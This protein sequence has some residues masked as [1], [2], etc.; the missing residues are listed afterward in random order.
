MWDTI[1]KPPQYANS[2]IH[3]FFEVK[4]TAL[5]HYEDKYEDFIA[6]TV[7]LRRRFTQEGDGSLLRAGDDKL[8]ADSLV[9]ST[10]QIWDVIKSQKDLNLPAHKVMVAN[11]RCN[12]IKLDQLRNLTSDQAWQSMAQDSSSRLIRDFGRHSAALVDSCMKGYEVEAMYFD[13]NVRT[14]HQADLQAKLTATVSGPFK[15]QLN[16]LVAELMV[17]FD[18][19]FR[20]AILDNLLGAFAATAEKMSRDTL[21]AFDERVQEFLVTGTDL[22]AD[23]ARD[24]LAVELH[25]HIER[26][27]H[28]ATK[29]ALHAIEGE[30]TK[31]I[32][33]PAVE[34][35]QTFPQ[36]LWSKLDSVRK[37]A[38]ASSSRDLQQRLSGYALTA[39]EQKS[40]VSKLAAAADKKL[41]DLLQEA[42]LTRVAKMRDVFNN[43]FQ[44]DEHGTPRT[45]RPKDNIPQLA[46]QARREAARVLALLAVK[47]SAD[48]AGGD[49]VETAIMNM[50]KKDI[51]DAVPGSSNS[52]TAADCGSSSR[53]SFELATATHWPDVKQERVLIAPHE[54]RLAWREFMSASALSVQQAQMTQQANLMAGK[55]SAPIWALLAIVFLGWNEFMV[56]LWNPLYLIIGAVLFILGRQMYGELD[57]DAELQ[58]GPIMG[59]I[60]IYHKLGGVLHKV[61]V[62]NVEAAQHLGGALVEMV[63]NP[64]HHDGGRE[65]APHS[66]N[67]STPLQ[68]GAVVHHQQRMQHQSAAGLKQRGAGSGQD[69]MQMTQLP[70]DDGVLDNEKD[71]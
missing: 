43:R 38:T 48:Y 34:L 1:S 58:R 61:A 28:L 39:E 2:K 14:E 68:D 36:N 59:L 21:A 46:R 50:V 37:Q 51:D 26:C 6:D 35:L 66:G 42:A 70:H 62:Q 49:A 60:N 8:P 55:R 29:E 12:E 19:D 47:R 57:V 56:V 45:W 30:L 15:A 53:D 69:G 24:K 27:K 23:E 32:A 13:S 25:E 16:L 4:Y 3:D 33:V 22:T 7:V 9:L 54:A 18:K 31:I 10:K 63:Q 67:T 17:K 20:L 71:A 41:G 64:Q 5:P 44:L 40:L 65:Q 11:I 52:S